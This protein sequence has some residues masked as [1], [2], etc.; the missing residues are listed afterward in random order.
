M[1]SYQTLKTGNLPT[2]VGFPSPFQSALRK[3]F[4]WT[5][6]SLVFQFLTSWS[7]CDVG[8]KLSLILDGP[9]FSPFNLPILLILVTPH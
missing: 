4:L 8:S 9:I 5:L 3:K 7:T 6:A 2:V 1:C